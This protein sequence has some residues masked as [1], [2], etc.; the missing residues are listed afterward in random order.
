MF[1]FFG[2]LSLGGLSGGNWLG[3][4][5]EQGWRSPRRTPY[6]IEDSGGLPPPLG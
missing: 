5:L 3:E 6:K 4:L 2:L 1:S